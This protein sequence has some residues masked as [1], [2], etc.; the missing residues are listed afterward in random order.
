MDTEFLEFI[1][2]SI[3]QPS[4]SYPQPG[5]AECCPAQMQL[6]IQA[7]T[8]G[9]PLQ[10]SGDSSLWSSLLSSTLPQNCSWLG[11]WNAD[12][13]PPP[14]LLLLDSIFF[15]SWESIPGRKLQCVWS[16]SL[17]FSPRKDH[18]PIC[19][20]P[21]P[22]NSCFTYFSHFYKFFMAEG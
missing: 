3:S 15:R 6:S 4:N 7:R 8:Q 12:L 9:N 1:L 10:I 5:H 2:R 16:S 19:L 18:S 21:T 11:R 22:K 13:F 20:C 17:G 14:R